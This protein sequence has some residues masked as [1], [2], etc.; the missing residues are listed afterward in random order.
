M[1]GCNRLY[2]SPRVR[3]NAP[4]FMVFQKKSWSADVS[5]R[6]TLHY[7]VR[8]QLISSDCISK[9]EVSKIYA[10]SPLKPEQER[11]IKLAEEIARKF[12]KWQIPDGALDVALQLQD[13]LDSVLKVD[14][15]EASTELEE[16]NKQDDNGQLTQVHDQDIQQEPEY[17]E[18]SEGEFE[19]WRVG[20][21]DE[22]EPYQDQDSTRFQVIDEHFQ[23]D[24]EQEGDGG[25]KAIEEDDG[26]SEARVSGD[27]E[28]EEMR[29]S[30]MQPEIISVYS[31]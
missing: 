24:F 7:W 5:S 19:Q 30:G 31:D 3:P 1:P 17:Q 15:E 9:F 25:Q 23:Q 16:R 4:Y 13:L 12:L 2:P 10:E 21:E 8:S 27:Q 14:D 28:D 22:Q 18:R 11:E 20:R 29:S 26:W 6:M